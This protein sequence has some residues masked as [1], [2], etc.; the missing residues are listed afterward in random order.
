MEIQQN[1]MSM[2]PLESDIGEYKINIKLVD[3][4]YP[5]MNTTY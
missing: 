1:V 2:Y 4:G 5:S 3:T